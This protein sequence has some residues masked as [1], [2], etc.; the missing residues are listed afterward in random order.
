[1]TAPRGSQL[2]Y[3][4]HRAPPPE[5]VGRPRSPTTS[6]SSRPPARRP[7]AAHSRLHP[8]P[9]KCSPART[10]R[11]EHAGVKSRLLARTGPGRGS[12]ARGA[13]WAHLAPEGRAVP[14]VVQN[15]AAQPG[16][17]PQR[18]AHRLHRRCARRRALE[19]QPATLPDEHI[20]G[21][22]GQANEARAV[23][24]KR[25]GRRGAVRVSMRQKGRTRYPLPLSNNHTAPRRTLTQV[26]VVDRGRHLRASLLRGPRADQPYTPA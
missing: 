26:R 4:P 10:S 22:P 15:A 3:S 21:P 9:G 1:M 19:K 11:F 13:A 17:T 16:P 14:P 25:P 2:L 5:R 20:A 24:Q 23:W 7:S 18:A 8:A 6:G 12:R